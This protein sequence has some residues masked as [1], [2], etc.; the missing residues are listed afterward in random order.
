LC[1]VVT[2]S[3][4]R[5][6]PSNFHQFFAPFKVSPRLHLLPPE[7]FSLCMRF[8][9]LPLGHPIHHTIPSWQSAPLFP[10]PPPPVF[11]PLILPIN[12]AVYPPPNCFP[13]SW[14]GLR[15]IFF[16]LFSLLLR[17][18]S[19]AHNLSPFSRH[20]LRLLPDRSSPLFLLAKYLKLHSGATHLFSSRKV[21][22]PSFPPA[23][24]D[25]QNMLCHFMLLT[26]G[27]FYMEVVH[28]L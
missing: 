19:Y 17:L 28:F 13:S 9:G 16:A 10:P 5:C 18:P 4:Q 12:L 24:A 14:F 8:W 27:L 6:Q 20:L 22:V 11:P 26:L 21:H 2:S 15:S 7:L 3:A 25:G 1:S 23:V